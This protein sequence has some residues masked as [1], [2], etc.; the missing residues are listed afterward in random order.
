[1]DNQTDIRISLGT[2]RYNTDNEAGL[3]VQEIS[4]AVDSDLTILL[5]ASP[6]S[7]CLTE[8]ITA[9]SKKNNIIL[10]VDKT[11]EN[12]QGYISKVLFHERAL[13][14][15]IE[16]HFVDYQKCEEIYS[17]IEK[18]ISSIKRNSSRASA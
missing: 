10:F 8:A 13:D 3:D 5:P 9:K 11:F 16:K 7:F 18:K 2:F 17:L 6:G 12:S 4:T 1:L 14:K 15:G